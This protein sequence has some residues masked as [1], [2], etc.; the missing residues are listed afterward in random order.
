MKHIGFNK[1][2]LTGKEIQYMLEAVQSGKISG[3]GIFTK[4]SQEFFEKKFGFRKVLLTHSCTAALEMA[5]MLL[6]LKEGDEVIA[7][8]FTFVSTVNAFVLRGARIVFADSSGE[9]PCMD[10]HRIE[11]LISSSTKAIIPVHYA[12]IACDMDVITALGKKYNLF[13]VEDA[14][15]SLDSCYKGKPLGSLGDLS[16]FSFHETKNIS[17]GE[18]GMLA[19]NNE[20]FIRRAEIIREKG[21]NRAAFFRGEIQQYEWVDIGSSYLPSDM[22]AAFLFAQL[23][24]LENIQ[25]KRKMIWNMYYNRL[26]DLQENGKL[27]LPFIPDYATNNAHLFYIICN[28]RKE[29]TALIQHLAEAGIQALFHYLPLHK[30][31]YYRD[32]YKGMDLPMADHY[33]DCLLR[34]PMYFE[35]TEEDVNRVTETINSFYK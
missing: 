15:H 26:K 17:S 1:P 7:P 31:E 10:V 4:K 20:R 27:K 35:L 2:W 12:G 29:R 5:A 30:S 6:D 8:A 21:T 24:Q 28:N 33:S 22:I 16:A 9:N 23:E 13:I 34:L 18:G 14:A 3:D 32:K 19:I 11:S 25:T